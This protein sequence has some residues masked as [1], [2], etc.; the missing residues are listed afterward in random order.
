MNYE[1]LI[2]YLLLILRFRT[3]L[4]SISYVIY[5]LHACQNETFHFTTLKENAVTTSYHLFNPHKCWMSANAIKTTYHSTTNILSY[6]NLMN[7]FVALSTSFVRFPSPIN[8][9]EAYE[10]I[11]RI[12]RQDGAG[13]GHASIRFVWI[14]KAIESAARPHDVC[15]YQK[16]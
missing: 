2:Y 7:N 16:G 8:S 1:I 11:C 3:S 5:H 15:R 6:I 4:F 13:R 12:F 14:V 9:G 10:G